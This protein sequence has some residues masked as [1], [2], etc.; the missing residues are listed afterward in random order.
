M[1]E[2]LLDALENGEVEERIAAVKQIAEG[3]YTAAL[4]HL[5]ETLREDIDAGVRYQAALSLAKFADPASTTDLLGALR[6]DDLWVRVAVTD[7]LIRIGQPSVTGLVDALRD[8]NHAVRRAAAKALGKIGAG[9]AVM[10]LRV[11]LIDVDA[12]VRRFAAE[13]LGRIGDEKSVDVLGDA[14]RDEHERVR[15][16]A[17]SALV[18]IGEP[19]IPILLDAVNDANP[20][21]TITAVFSLKEMGYRPPPET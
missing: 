4:P 14:L 17:A 20:N 7:A 1:L 5:A 21:V 2:K 6:Q 11:A 12:D 9:S 15:H 8:E 10:S 3:Q 13:A 16:A 18:K 19:S